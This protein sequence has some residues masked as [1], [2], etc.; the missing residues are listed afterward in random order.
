MSL[1]VTVIIPVYNDQ[2]GIDA[3]LA[4]LSLQTWPRDRCEVIVIDNASNPPIRLNPAFADFARIVI[5]STPGAYAARNAGVAAARG[6]VLAFTDADC[7]PDRNWIAAGVAA[8]EREAG[9]CIVG[10]EVSLSLSQRPS[11]I[12]RY[13]Y[14]TGFV[15]MPTHHPAE[16][17]V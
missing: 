17:K 16:D 15:S 6:E 7:V 13:Q 4:A 10:G 9:L 8:L 11:A 5:C 1:L 12:E 3:C 14:L 2:A